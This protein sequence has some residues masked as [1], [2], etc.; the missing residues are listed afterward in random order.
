M[1]K[2]YHLKNV[3][4]SSSDILAKESKDLALNEKYC[5]LSKQHFYNRTSLPMTK[6]NHEDLNEIDESEYRLPYSI[7]YRRMF[8][9][10]YY[11]APELLIPTTTTEMK[12]VLPSPQADVYGLALLLWESINRVVPYVIFNQDELISG[13]TKGNAQLPMFDTTSIIFKEIFETCL[14]AESSKRL[15]DVSKFITML[16]DLRLLGFERNKFEV[17]EIVEPVSKEKKSEKNLKNSD[18][19][20]KLREKIYFSPTNVEKDPQKRIENALTSDNLFDTRDNSKISES[21]Q[22]AEFEP[23]VASFN[24]QPGI[25]QDEAALERIRKTVENQREITPKKPTRKKDEEHAVLE[26]SKN[27]T[28]FQSFFDFNRLQTPKVDKDVIYERTST[29]KKRLKARGDN[30]QK[31]SVKGLFDSC[32]DKTNDDADIDGNFEYEK[33]K[34]ALHDQ[35]DKMNAELNMIVQGYNKK[36]F[37]EEIVTE[38]K[39]REKPNDNFAAASF[40]NQGMQSKAHDVSRSFEQLPNSDKQEIVKRS[41]SD[42]I[43]SSLKRFSSSDSFSLPHTPIARQNMIRRN[44]WLSDGCK[45]TITT[46]VSDEIARRSIN[47][48]NNSPINDSQPLKTNNINKKKYNVNIKIHHND[49]DTTTATAIKDKSTN[50]NQSQNNHNNNSSVKINLYNS[51]SKS[52]PIV[53]INNVDFNKTTYTEDVN[54]KYY[55]MMPEMLSDVIQNKRDRSSFLIANE[56]NDE[57]Q[58]RKY[59]NVTLRKKKKSVSLSEDYRMDDDDVEEKVIV[60]LPMKVRDTIRLIETTFNPK[61][62]TSSGKFFTASKPTFQSDGTQTDKLEVETEVNNGNYEGAD[63]LMHASESIQKLDEIINQNIPPP[64]PPLLIRNNNNLETIVNHST[65]QTQTPKKIT[66]KVTVN[67]K[68][69][70]GRSSDVNQLKLIQSEQARHSMC[71]SAELIK[72]MQAHIKG[73]EVSKIDHCMNNDQISASCSSLVSKDGTSDEV[74]IPLSTKI[75]KYFCRNCGFTMI[76]AEIWK[77]SEWILI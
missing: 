22:S 10:H 16:E 68:K 37:M 36:D 34:K 62:D 59:D 74:A 5:K 43:D 25:L 42:L 26:M 45:P 21:I 38:L 23:H 24:Q 41:E 70:T 19:R 18:Q 77:R 31:R 14:Q 11:Q 72:R 8:S 29:L 75:Q 4:E 2:I 50:I 46:S 27:S 15:A 73:N 17:L 54:R 56:R 40:L 12:Y 64:P 1:G 52:S 69:I 51:A 35:F 48:I 33:E 6:F 7:A 66:T 39:Q 47:F 44:A 58:Q 20:D 76:P 61:F 63:C 32:D 60:P 71:N 65:I 67:L 28:M 30:K 55:P 9:M 57:Q 3:T 13:L 49:L 53:K